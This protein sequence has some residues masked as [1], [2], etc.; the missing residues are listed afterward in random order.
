MWHIGYETTVR[1]VIEEAFRI[2]K[3]YPK[4]P[5]PELYE[6]FGLYTEQVLERKASGDVLSRWKQS[7]YPDYSISNP[8]MNDCKERPN[9]G[10]SCV[11]KGMNGSDFCVDVDI[12]IVGN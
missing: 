12:Q 9:L 10:N 3:A 11:S 7:L 4:M 2:S 5:C 6:A 8:T 1:E